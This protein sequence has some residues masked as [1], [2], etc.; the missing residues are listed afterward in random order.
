MGKIKPYPPVKFF[1]AITTNAE[2]NL[3]NIYGDLEKLFSPIDSKSIIFNFDRFTSY[4]QT[5][6]GKGLRKQIVSF[7]TLMPAEKLPVIKTATNEIEKNYLSD[8]KRTVNIDPGYL[9]AARMVLAT[10]KDYDHRIYLGMGIFGDVHYRFRK[11]RFQIN[12]WTYPDYQQDEIRQ[13]FEELRTVYLD[14]LKTW[15]S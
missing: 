2:S 14:Q 3:N 10:T 5:E 7:L 8:G 1:S 11:G 13:Y 15:N 6:M 9:T 4:Y 12:E